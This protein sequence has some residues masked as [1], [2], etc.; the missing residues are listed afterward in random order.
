MVNKY[1]IVERLDNL[2]FDGGRPPLPSGQK[3][4]FDGLKYR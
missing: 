4:C 1:I 3:K 2:C